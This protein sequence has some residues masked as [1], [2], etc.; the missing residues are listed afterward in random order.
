MTKTLCIYAGYT[1][2]FNGQNYK[3]QDVYGSEMNIIQIG[4]WFVKKYKYE[5]Y[6]FVL[7]L[8]ST[9][10]EIKHNGVHYVD[11]HSLHEFNKTID[12]MIVNR[13]MNYFI[14]FESKAKQTYYYAQDACLNHMYEGKSLA[15]YGKHFIHNICKGNLIDGFICIS[16]WQK[17]NIKKQIGK[18]HTPFHII[19]NGISSSIPERNVDKIIKNKFIYCSDPTRGLVTFLDCIIELQKYIPDCSIVVFRSTIYTEAICNKLKLIN[20]KKVY[21]KVS[22]DIV[23]EE[24]ITS[25]IWFYPVN[26]SEAYCNCAAESQLYNTICIYNNLGALETT[27]G[28]RGIAL[29][30]NES[31]YIEYAVQNILALI[32][33]TT[34]KQDLRKKGYEWATQ[35]IFEYK[36]DEWYKIFTSNIYVEVDIM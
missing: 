11:F 18:I 6:I 24:F 16:E 8:K 25:D 15:N 29:N 2:P 13:F 14:H 10:M 31:N 26:I 17:Q 19:G 20:N 1:P 4:E 28:D 30:H 12:I 34:L 9:N 23:I 3:D 7:H 36:I 21:D 35:Q 27:I 32:Q 33:N 5:V 22:H